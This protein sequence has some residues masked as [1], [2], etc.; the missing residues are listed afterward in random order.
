MREKFVSKVKPIQ[1]IRATRWI[2]VL[3]FGPWI[4]PDPELGIDSPSGIFTV[5]DIC[6]RN[7]SN[8]NW[9]RPTFVFTVSKSDLHHQRPE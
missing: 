9:D 1:G 5:Q 2:L 3:E 8:E 4:K 7:T 6:N